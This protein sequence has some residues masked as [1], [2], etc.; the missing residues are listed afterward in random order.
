MTVVVVL[1]GVLALIGCSGPDEDNGGHSN[2]VEP[3]AGQDEYRGD[4]DSDEDV[5][6]DVGGDGTCEPMTKFG[7]DECGMIDDGCGGTLEFDEYRCVDGVA[8]EEA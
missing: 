4:G 1:V 5:R 6:G 3:E 8:Q 7:A 2:V